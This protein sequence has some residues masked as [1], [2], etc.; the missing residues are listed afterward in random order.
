[1]LHQTYQNI[2]YIVIDDGSLVF[3]EESIKAFISK[4]KSSNI[5]EVIVLKK[6][7]NEGTVKALNLG[8]S[9]A[10]GEI[11]F[12]LAGDDCFADNDVLSD[13]VKEFDRTGADIITAKR[14]VYDSE[15]ENLISIEPNDNQIDIIKSKPPQELFEEMVGENIIF[16]C[17]TARTKKSFD[18]F[19]LYDENYK[20]IE[21]FSSN[22]QLLRN[23]QQIHFFD[24]VVVKYRSSGISSLSKINKTYFNES[25]TLFNKEILPYTINS[26]RAKKAYKMW[27]KKIAQMIKNKQ[28]KIKLNKYKN[29][30]VY[31]DALSYLAM[32][33]RIRI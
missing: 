2:Q 31:E 28:F 29:N 15:L 16:G 19:G 17:C 30:H 9:K 1:V 13:W 27:K 21:D 3:D 18:I 33:S 5:F 26:K 24:R 6:E 12:N 20:Y 25:D 4:N 7:K 14:A 8:I 22:M 11:I 32:R 23:G 10:K